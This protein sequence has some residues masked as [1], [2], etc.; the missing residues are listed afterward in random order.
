MIASKVPASFSVTDAH[1]LPVIVH[2]RDGSIHYDIRGCRI[3]TPT[4]VVGVQAITNVESLW[5]CPPLGSFVVLL[6]SGV[7][8]DGAG[9]GN[10]RPASNTG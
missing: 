9:V 6:S 3:F 7:G 5:A 2:A 10:I 8:G 1:L 4:C